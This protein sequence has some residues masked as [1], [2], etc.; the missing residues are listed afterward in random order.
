MVLANDPK[1]QE[2][3]IKQ[4]FGRCNRR[5]GTIFGS[6]YL[7][8]SQTSRVNA[9]IQIKAREVLLNHDGG[10]LINRILKAQKMIQP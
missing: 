8:G 2:K 1:M 9:W 5:Q 4:M 3:E 7:L 6:V 10:K